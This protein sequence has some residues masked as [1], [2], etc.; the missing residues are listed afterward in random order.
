MNKTTRKACILLCLVSMIAALSAAGTAACAEGMSFSKSDYNNVSEEAADAVIS[1]EG[2]HG[3]LSDPA[4]GRSGNP[5]VIERKGVYRVTGSSDG[6]TIQI[7][8]PK[9][10]GNI[11]LV[12]DHV[13]MTNADGP[14]IESKAA[15]QTIIQCV[16]ENRLVSLADKGAALYSEDD[17]TMNG[18]G[19]LE[20]ESG[21]NGI[22]CK[23]VL[24]VTGSAL[25]IRAVNDGLKG[26]KGFLMDGGS[27]TVTDSYE[28]L[29]G[30]QIEIR[31]GDL[32]VKASDDG[33]NAAGEDGLQ[34]DVVISGGS[35]FIDATGDA[36]DSNR[37]IL[38]TGGTT[39]V[40]G[41]AN[42]R[43][44]IFDKGDAADARLSISGGTVLA[45]GS[46]EKAKNFTD[47]TQYSRLE[48]IA[49][50]AGDV[51]TT[52]DG[53]GVALT[54]TRDFS[55]VIYSGPGFSPESS[56]RVLSAGSEA[57]PA[58]EQDFSAM[59]ENV[60]MKLAIR[61]AREAR[62]SVSE[63]DSVPVGSVIVKDGQIVGQGHDQVLQFND[64][65]GHGA[66]AAIRSAGQR[67]GTADLTGCTLYTTIEPC[68]MCEY[69]CRLAG[70]ERIYYGCTREEAGLR[71]FTR[72]DGDALPGERD[73][74]GDEYLVCL[75]RDACLAML[76]ARAEQLPPKA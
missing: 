9:K 49:G 20:I 8:E 21:K 27:V 51:I 52:D 1:L 31:G 39:L 58:A 3:T 42:S 76:D 7:R 50:H 60:Y 33:L 5:V 67:L 55:C 35:V 34:G 71:G 36:I 47:G 22:Q 66:I 17:L 10:S 75:D 70:I 29:E 56:I 38:I 40:E 43:N 11:Y 15:E 63:P 19:R 16:G 4:R 59:A 72:E 14:C 73:S 53:S 23:S 30:G 68:T 12:L 48:P 26:E 37:S 54:A 61:E 25:T 64:P 62:D 18:P 44:S 57:E 24:R 41:P 45:I 65:T 2:D 6:V 28:G 46:V 74:F 13:T 69:A 32:H